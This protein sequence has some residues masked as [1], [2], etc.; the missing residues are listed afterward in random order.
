M[1]EKKAKIFV[2]LCGS[3]N[4]LMAEKR[5][6]VK[7]AHGEKLP[8]HRNSIL[9]EPNRMFTSK[10]TIRHVVPENLQGRS[11]HEGGLCRTGA[12]VSKRPVGSSSIDKQKNPN[13][14]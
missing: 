11:A 6:T 5:C 2:E 4:R 13:L 10:P 8:I 14:A 12:A 3:S 7:N 1:L 9:K